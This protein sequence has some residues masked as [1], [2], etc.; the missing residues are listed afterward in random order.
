MPISL[1]HFPAQYFQERLVNLIFSDRTA[2]AAL[3]VSLGKGTI[4]LHGRISWHFNDTR[5]NVC[6]YM[7]LHAYLG[8]ACLHHHGHPFDSQ[9]E[10][11]ARHDAASAEHY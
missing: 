7:M 5:A 11:G 1:Q 9:S 3:M 2:G 6:Y 4:T 8:D 10:V